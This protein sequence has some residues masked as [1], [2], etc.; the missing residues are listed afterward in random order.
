MKKIVS[1]I[2]AEMLLML[3]CTATAEGFSLRNGIQFGNSMDDV[4]AKETLAIKK[5]EDEA[6]E[7]DDSDYPYSITTENG[8]VAGVAGA[9]VWYRFDAD[10]TLREVEYVLPSKSKKDS[11]DSEYETLYKG[12]ANKYGTPLGYTDGSCY[13]I[14]GN[15]LESS[16]FMAY[17][18]D[19][20]GYYGDVRDYDEWDIDTGEYHVKIELVQYYYGTSYSSIS[21]YNTISYTYFT[22]EDLQEA[23][24]EK[25]AENE[26]VYADL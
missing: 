9:Y 11:S 19:S 5:I 14:T 6:E 23:K 10:K 15:A 17:F 7:D 4:L 16:V 2:L 3:C 18:Y 21:Y 20:L 12:L 13:I 8:T 1:L 26:A 25:R 22:D 24:D